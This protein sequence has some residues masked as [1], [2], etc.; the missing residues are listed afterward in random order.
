[1]LACIARQCERGRGR[2][3]REVVLFMFTYT[4]VCVSCVCVIPPVCV[5]VCV[6]ARARL[7]PQ[8]VAQRV[9][10]S[11][12]NAMQSLLVF[13][14]N[15]ARRNDMVWDQLEEGGRVENPPPPPSPYRSRSRLEGLDSSERFTKG[16]VVSTVVVVLPAP[17]DSQT[18]PPPPPPPPPNLFLS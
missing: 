3:E 12:L 9:C 4:C 5:R 16:V 1:M 17:R 10:E 15:L 13:V 6:C 2:E 18:T 14:C 8:R 11:K 7:L